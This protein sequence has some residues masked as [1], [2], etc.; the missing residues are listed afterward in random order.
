MSD[1]QINWGFNC[2][3]TGVHHGRPETIWNL[4]LFQAAYMFGRDEFQELVLSRIFNDAMQFVN[5]TAGEFDQEWAERVRVHAEKYY[6]RTLQ[7]K[8][9]EISR[10]YQSEEC[11]QDQQDAVKRS[12]EGMLNPSYNPLHPHDSINL[13][14]RI[15]GTRASRAVSNGS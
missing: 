7:H 6:L 12:R 2:L 5:T 8:L 13:L 10:Y 15:L 9:G 4:P 14:C 11:K 3:T 1:L